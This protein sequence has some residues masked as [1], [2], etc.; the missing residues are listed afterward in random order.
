MDNLFEQ[1]MNEKK[2][3]MVNPAAENDQQFGDRY[4]NI[5]NTIEQNTKDMRDFV[6]QKIYSGDLEKQNQ[7]GELD[8]AHDYVMKNVK[9]NVYDSNR[10]VYD[11]IKKYGKAEPTEADRQK[12]AGVFGY[13][14]N[15][16][17]KVVEEFHGKDVSRQQ[18][19]YEVCREQNEHVTKT[20]AQEMNSLNK[21]V[22]SVSETLKKG[23]GSVFAK[24]WNKKKAT[25]PQNMSAQ[26]QQNAEK[27]AYTEFRFNLAPFVKN[28]KTKWWFGTR[29]Y[30]MDG[31][32][33]KFKDGELKPDA[34]NKAFLEGMML[35]TDKDKVRDNQTLQRNRARK[36][37][38]L[39]RLTKEMIEYGDKFDPRKMTD[40]FV[41]DHIAELQEYYARLNA[42][43]SI[44]HDNKWF[45]F[46][47]DIKLKKGERLQLKDAKDPIFAT[48][49]KTHILDMVNPVSNFIEAHLRA[50]CI[51][52]NAEFPG[53]KLG[54]RKEEKH[55]MV[56]LN[57]DE[58]M[59]DRVG[60]DLNEVNNDLLDRSEEDN[61]FFAFG[62]DFGVVDLNHMNPNAPVLTQEDKDFYAQKLQQ[63]RALMDNGSTRQILFNK[64]NRVRY[65]QTRPL[66]MDISKVIKP[67]M[68]QINQQ[69]KTYM[70]QQNALELDAKKKVPYIPYATEEPGKLI[71]GSEG[72]YVDLKSVHEKLHSEEGSVMYLYY[73]PEIDQIY[74]KMYTVLRLQAEL[75]ARKKTI[76]EKLKIRRIRE[77]E[78]GLK[79][80][81]KPKVT[82]NEWKR[83]LASIK[84]ANSRI[85]K[86]DSK[87]PYAAFMDDYLVNERM[88]RA[89]SE[90][91]EI[92]K[93]LEY[94]NTQI[95]TCRKTLRFFLTD[96]ARRNYTDEDYTI[97]RNFLK[98]ENL[99]YMFNMNKIEQFD[100]ILTEAMD[101]TEEELLQKAGN[102][103]VPQER[104][105]RDRSP[106]KRAERIRQVRNRARVAK[107][108]DAA[109]N[110]QRWK[111][112][113]ENAY[114]LQ[115]INMKPVDFLKFNNKGD[116]PVGTK[117]ARNKTMDNL[118][119][120]SCVVSRKG[121]FAPG[122]YTNRVEMV[123]IYQDFKKKKLI[124]NPTFEHFMADVEVKIRLLEKWNN[125]YAGAFRRQRDA[126]YAYLDTN[127][128]EGKSIQYLKELKKKLEDKAVSLDA[129]ARE[130][131]V[132][133]AQIVEQRKNTDQFVVIDP[134]EV[135]S[136][137]YKKRKEKLDNCR[138]VIDA[139][140]T[141][142]LMRESQSQFQ[143]LTEETYHH[144]MNARML[145]LEV[146][147]AR[148]EIFYEA[149]KTFVAL[150][151]LSESGKAKA[152]TRD[153]VAR[154]AE[155]T[156]KDKDYV[157]KE[158]NVQKEADDL[159]AAIR[160]IPVNQ[161]LVDM[162][163]KIIGNDNE[164]FVPDDNDILTLLKY[165]N[166]IGTLESVFLADPMW[167]SAP[168]LMK[169]KDY[170]E[171]KEN[172]ELREEIEA[173]Y[174]L[175]KPLFMGFNSYL[176]Y[177][178]M[179]GSTSFDVTRAYKGEDELTEE[180]RT[181][182]DD[183]RVF[184]HS[185]M[186]SAMRELEKNVKN[187]D[188][189]LGEGYTMRLFR[190]VYAAGE[191]LSLGDMD[192]WKK[193]F[194]KISKDGYY[195]KKD[196]DKEDNKWMKAAA[197]QALARWPY[198][199]EEF[200]E[201]RARF[202]TGKALDKTF[203]ELT[204]K[205]GSAFVD[206]DE[207][208]EISAT[209]SNTETMT[210][211]GVS[212][213]IRMR[214]DEELKRT[215]YSPKAFRYLF[216]KVE[217]NG[218]GQV[219]NA[220]SEINR[221]DNTGL[222]NSFL[223][224]NSKL[225]GEP[226]D[227][228]DKKRFYRRM[229]NNEVI[230]HMKNAVSFRITPE[231]T[232]EKY[233]KNNFKRLYEETRKFAAIK[234]LYE[235][236]KDI[237]DDPYTLMSNNL[238]EKTVTSIHNAFGPKTRSVYT[239][240][241]DMIEAYAKSHFVDK[242]GHFDLGISVEDMKSEE[243]DQNREKVEK[244][245][246]SRQDQFK[247]LQMR[248][249]AEYDR[250]ILAEKVTEA[251]E[252]NKTLNAIIISNQQSAFK[253][254]QKKEF[255]GQLSDV[256][257]LLQNEA[258]TK[259]VKKRSKYM[260]NIDMLKE[261]IL[262]LHEQEK[263]AEIEKRTADAER[264]C[265]QI[266]LAEATLNQNRAAL[267]HVE[268]KILE[269]QRQNKEVYDRYNETHDKDGNLVML[270]KESVSGTT[271]ENIGKYI[272]FHVAVYKEIKPIYDEFKV[273][274]KNAKEGTGANIFTA[275]DIV[276]RFKQNE[277]VDRLRD[278]KKLDLYLGLLE[279][280]RKYFDDKKNKY[281]VMEKFKSKTNELNNR[282]KKQYKDAND[283]KSL[284]MKAAGE[285]QV[286]EMTAARKFVKHLLMDMDSKTDN[287]VPFI[288]DYVRLI[289]LTLKSYGVAMNG[290]VVED[291]IKDKVDGKL[292]EQEIRNISYDEA[293]KIGDAHIELQHELYQ[294]LG[295]EKKIEPAKKSSKKKET[296]T[297]DTKKN[298]K[299]EINI[300]IS[301][302]FD[303]TDV[304]K[305]K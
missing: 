27:L 300:N 259:L 184:H 126:N 115:L 149:D 72:V 4:K 176:Q 234:E 144:E 202:D 280:D 192:K 25:L 33:M 250:N 288:H 80:R 46:G 228:D 28:Y 139:V 198:S 211:Q 16:A 195:K 22:E 258:L 9:E 285:Q 73:G 137:I 77:I 42:F 183:D 231:M 274:L 78:A 145:E 154:V 67:S 71:A 296:K 305:L 119:M 94:T 182:F 268:T 287:P 204:R 293:D 232:D 131:W 7:T 177:K 70:E 212:M 238:D 110:E 104:Q 146:Q 185:K 225:Q 41:A 60:V 98:K 114:F 18:A 257:L 53:R 242:E 263:L 276:R 219:A 294:K 89:E 127:E 190:Q 167:G 99:S 129:S 178:G 143:E 17:N 290:E 29:Y 253:M 125:H 152:L 289:N 120:L 81:N 205:S 286:A 277:M 52:Q 303:I 267:A 215:G 97:I 61:R 43:K 160:E 134:E 39:K 203:K 14:K 245:L 118:A 188:E 210:F 194:T 244:E 95:K 58:D 252:V 69:S 107:D 44:F 117:E 124:T 235:H 55:V 48:L 6:N 208:A 189:L 128:L 197:R 222:V 248:V 266:A 91:D 206:T 116:L 100:D 269:H 38:V 201:E 15:F 121:P 200:Y 304:E 5:G 158:K 226:D 130:V 256:N 207:A 157:N 92:S 209:I 165:S 64:L 36:A 151:K 239:M 135:Q 12:K 159:V 50:N 229:W 180:Q 85:L 186:D 40:R 147:T 278:L 233:I 108:A 32:R 26:D 272:E 170:F 31:N 142:I 162:A 168:I 54:F 171:R 262:P 241:F 224:R 181:L 87:N 57:Q 8:Y 223:A 153:V 35:E 19:M 45:F 138:A 175:L 261:Q 265:E 291:Q 271:T 105:Q 161:G 237:L 79:D 174:K 106:R 297:K 155:K 140:N 132:D 156:K 163:K 255:A 23:R 275:E 282:I 199:F 284:E 49:V 103:A 3:Q 298:D 218:V 221:E 24:L 34:Y 65:E 75:A 74:G 299:D 101:Q 83:E 141:E 150:K 302:S 193:I 247:R 111:Q 236:E 88:K 51:M 191:K 109:Y 216:K 10:K 76:D 11:N 37:E 2:R 227:M 196:S 93:K 270:E 21:Y 301:G 164:D 295:L 279:V 220:Q 166:I 214:L 1:K 217:T 292:S 169:L 281:N 246:R 13:F 243:K 254:V 213:N 273:F 47:K 179:S 30:T 102:Q 133:P 20:T 136:P 173:K 84:T 123:M 249:R 82:K 187:A 148:K 260:E 63:E 56:D 112:I 172:K 251:D 122:F 240:Y 230:K 86:N 66:S 113:N 59:M 264:I 96:P 90:Y 68:D 62:N 283:P